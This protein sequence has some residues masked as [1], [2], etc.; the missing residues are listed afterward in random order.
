MTQQTKAAQAA[1][2]LAY[3]DKFSQLIRGAYCEPGYLSA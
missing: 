1:P 2:K 3:F